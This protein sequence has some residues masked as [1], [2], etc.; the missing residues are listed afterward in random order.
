MISFGLLAYF[1]LLVGFNRGWVAL[2]GVLVLASCAG[3]IALFP[4]PFGD[5]IHNTLVADLVCGSKVVGY[6]ES[7][8]FHSDSITTRLLDLEKVKK[9]LEEPR[10][11]NLL[12][13]KLPE[14]HYI[15]AHGDFWFVFLQ[16]GLLGLFC[17]VIPLASIGLL[18]LR[19]F[20]KNQEIQYQSCFLAIHLMLACFAATF[21]VDN[22]IFDA[23]TGL[24]FSLCLSIGFAIWHFRSGERGG[25]R[26]EEA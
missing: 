13:G 8:A 25:F 1:V 19:Q 4:A 26:L 17:L 5:T 22:V 24:L 10:V 6:P 16:A 18:S 7:C 3:Q 15:H 9:V 21:L 23:P 12:F 11:V 2:I 14:R 20:F